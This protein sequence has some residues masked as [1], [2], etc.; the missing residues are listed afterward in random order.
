MVISNFYIL[1]SCNSFT[2]QVCFICLVTGGIWCTANIISVRGI[3]NMSSS[4]L[5]R[6]NDRLF[7][8][9]R[10]VVVVRVFSIFQLAEIR[11]ACSIV[12]FMVDI[13]VLRQEADDSSSISIKLLGGIDK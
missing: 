9:D 2:D 1:F 12:T 10:E 7:F 13:K 11:Y 6:V 3:N 8:I 4:T 5:P